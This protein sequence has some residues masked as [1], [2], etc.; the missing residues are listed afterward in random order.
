[1]KAFIAKVTGGTA[2]KRSSQIALQ[3]VHDM[4]TRLDF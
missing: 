2:I 1:M 3:I 4:L